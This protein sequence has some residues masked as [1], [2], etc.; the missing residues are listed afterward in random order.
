MK[1]VIIG[2]YL[3]MGMLSFGQEDRSAAKLLG[4]A[5]GKIINC[6]NGE[7]IYPLASVT[8]M[9]T[10]LITYDAISKGE[11]SM[12]DMV[13]IPEEARKVGGSRI[14]MMAKDRLSVRDL[15]KATAVYS[16]NNAAYS[17]AYYVGNGDL[18]RFVKRMNERAESMGMV[19]TSYYTPAGLPP[20]MTGTKMD[21]STVSDIYKLSM[22]LLKND[23]YMKIASMK[24]ASIRNGQQKFK[25]RN[26]LLGIDGIYGMKTGHHSMA[27]YNISIVSKKN[28]LNMI[29]IVFGSPDEKTRDRI[30]LEDL[31]EFYNNYGYV[32]ILVCGEKLGTLKVEDGVESQVSFYAEDSYTKLMAKNRKIEKQVKMKKNIKAPVE[33]GTVVGEYRILIDGKTYL[34]SDLIIKH[35]IEK[36][37][38]F[39]RIFN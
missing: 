28:D 20:Y 3:V 31:N 9:M 37:G 4:T 10:I 6:I 8:K 21:V 14:W 12:E 18:D 38:F 5:D 29:K 22:E 34:K 33:A 39:Q 13:D 2:I 17:L 15:L 26:K 32:D 35:S 11:I 27:G 16:A 23:D 19:N 1:K 25:N 7:K 30:V 24:D 36:M